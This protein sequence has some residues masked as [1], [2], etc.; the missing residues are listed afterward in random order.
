MRKKGSIV[1][2]IH[3]WKCVEARTGDRNNLEERDDIMLRL[4]TEI[5][6]QMGKVKVKQD[7]R[8]EANNHSREI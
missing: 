1:Y 4:F 8:I 3:E 5:E 7:W 2:R 6:N